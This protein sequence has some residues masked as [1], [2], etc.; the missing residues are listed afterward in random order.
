MRGPEPRLLQLG[1]QTTSGKGSRKEW[2]HGAGGTLGEFTASPLHCRKW[3]LYAQDIRQQL[4]G[5]TLRGRK[6][7]RDSLWTQLQRKVSWSVISNS[8]RPHRQYSH[9]AVLSMEF[10]GQQYWN[11]WPFP[12]SG[13]VFLTQRSNPRLLHCK[14]ILYH[15]SHHEIEQHKSCNPSLGGEDKG[16]EKKRLALF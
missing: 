6:T 2:R 10:S 13:G 14:Q 9:W 8:L 11:G 15:L 4:K 1:D 16:F 3:R 7:W 5:V 12:S